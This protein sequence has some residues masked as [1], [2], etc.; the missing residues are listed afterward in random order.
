MASIIPYS[1]IALDALGQQVRAVLL[2]GGLV[3]IPTETFYGLGVN[4]F[5]R[6][7]LDRLS[8]VKGRAEGKPILVLVGSPKDLASLAEHVPSAAAVLMEAFWPGALTI[9]FPARASVPA[10]LTAG[11]GRVGIRLS[12]CRPLRE[13]LQ[14]VGPLTGTSANRTGTPPAHTAREVEQAFGATVD[15]IIDA[16]PT[17]GGLPSTVVEA[18]ETLRI[19]REGA[20]PRSAIEAALSARGFF[21]KNA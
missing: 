8:A 16:G 9:L 5:D 15:V 17:P 18:D 14:Q 7:A 6:S 4:P 1:A 2:R 12:S 3:A 13:M 19:V 10:A 20:I 21:L 11:T